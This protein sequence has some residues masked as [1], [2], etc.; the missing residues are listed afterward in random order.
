MIRIGLREMMTFAKKLCPTV[1]N[2]TF[3]ESCGVADLITTC[4]GG[5]F[6]LIQTSLIQ[7]SLI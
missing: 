1:K 2:E 5:Q 6:S 4:I 7:P 3:F